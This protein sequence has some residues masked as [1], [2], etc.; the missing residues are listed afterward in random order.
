[1][2]PLRIIQ[3]DR[4]L[5]IYLIPGVISSTDGNKNEM[6]PPGLFESCL[7]SSS[8]AKNLAFYLTTKPSDS[9]LRIQI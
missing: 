8:A 1:M 5:D 4:F 6:I 3:S 2:Y 9:S 7:I